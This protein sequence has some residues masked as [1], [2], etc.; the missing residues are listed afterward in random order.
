MITKE[1]YSKEL[2]AFRKYLKLNPSELE[3]YVYALIDPRDHKV[4]YV[5]KGKTE[6]MFHHVM[7]S[8]SIQDTNS[9]KSLG[10]KLEKIK[11]IH[12]A[13][14]K[15][16]MRILHYGLTNEH[17]FI[18]ESVLIDVFSN[19]TSIDNNAIG[20]L[21]NSINGYDH[22]RGFCDVEELNRR[23]AVKEKVD[24]HPD[25]K[26][27][28][29]KINGTEQDD[30]DILERV[31]KYWRIDPN[32][33][34]KATYIAACRHGVVVGLYINVSGWKKDDNENRFYFEGTSVTDK[35]VLERYINKSIDFPKR[36]QYPIWYVGK[37]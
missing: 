13:G 11:D 4:F 37:W 16:D 6:R 33:A 29:I 7:E 34:N 21:T 15:V 30:K 23:A 2:I 8:L 27:L 35:K 28:A 26:I 14:E 18:V 12:N 17:A 24:I 1:S 25:E 5:G 31:R 22:R 3:Y 32:H 36:A 19:F 10:K 9:E 20:E